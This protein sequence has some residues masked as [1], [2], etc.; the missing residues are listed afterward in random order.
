MGKGASLYSRV[1]ARPSGTQAY[2]MA[3]GHIG[4]GGVGVRAQHTPASLCMQRFPEYMEDGGRRQGPGAEP[5]GARNV[6]VDRLA[7]RGGQR[8]YHAQGAQPF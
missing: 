5:L 4:L 3:R 7:G 8:R 2:G 6:G 1:T